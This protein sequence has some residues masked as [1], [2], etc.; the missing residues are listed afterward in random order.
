M[1]FV[2]S[3]EEVIEINHNLGGHL[4]ADSSLEFAFTAAEGKSDRRK[5]ALLWRAILIGHPFDDANKR[6]VEIITRVYAKEKKYLVN[7]KRLV[8]EIIEVSKENI[9][10]LKAI[11]R[12]IKYALTGN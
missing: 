4:R 10:D 1:K 5:L 6:T 2:L 9:N 12:R 7:T 11:E 3:K 8:K